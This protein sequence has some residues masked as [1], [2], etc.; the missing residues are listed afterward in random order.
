MEHSVVTYLVDPNGRCVDFYGRHKSIDG[1]IKNVKKHV[2]Q[3]EY[4]RLTA[5]TG[6]GTQAKSRNVNL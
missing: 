3:H 1:I 6:T 4:E 2:Q 5:A